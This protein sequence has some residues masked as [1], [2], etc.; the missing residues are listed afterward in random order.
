MWRSLAEYVPCMDASL[1][2]RIPFSLVFALFNLYRDFC[3]FEFQDLL[4]VW[5]KGPC[6]KGPIQ[7][8]AKLHNTDSGLKLP[9][10]YFWESF[11]S[12]SF[13][14]MIN[15]QLFSF[16]LLS[17]SYCDKDDQ[18][19]NLQ[20]LEM[21][22]SSTALIGPSISVG[23]LSLPHFRILTILTQIAIAAITSSGFEHFI[24]GCG[25]VDGVPDSSLCSRQAS[26]NRLSLWLNHCFGKI[27]QK[28]GSSTLVPVLTMPKPQSV[29]HIL[30]WGFGI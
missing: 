20:D 15:F 25:T 8:Y 27:L 4:L 17:I 18:N 6:R 2:S 24:N 30:L 26:S 29:S 12:A 1:C 16:H 14:L 22:N 21:F 9:Q 3:R 28:P 11:L 10:N 19:H 7:R 5:G 13:L 23:L